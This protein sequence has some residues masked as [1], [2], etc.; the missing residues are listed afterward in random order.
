[1]CPEPR[2][3]LPALRVS[4]HSCGEHLDGRVSGDLLSGAVDA[5]QNPGG[6]DD[7]DETNR[8]V[9]QSLR[10]SFV[11]PNVGWLAR[12]GTLALAALLLRPVPLASMRTCG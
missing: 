1:M 2:L 8:L 11:G 3:T 10:Q 5:D 9:E 7:N 4:Q 12:V 6:V